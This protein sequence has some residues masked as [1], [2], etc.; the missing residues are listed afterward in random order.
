MSGNRGE[1]DWS[2]IVL[3][4]SLHEDLSISSL[5]ALTERMLQPDKRVDEIKAVLQSDADLN[6]QEMVSAG[7]AR[8]R[9]W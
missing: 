7:L 2:E 1:E 8:S 5:A 9:T 3:A 6:F 4:Q